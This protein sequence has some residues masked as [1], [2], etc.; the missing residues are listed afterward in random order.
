LITIFSALAIH[1]RAK[2]PLS[3][4]NPAAL[5]SRNELSRNANKIEEPLSN[6]KSNLRAKKLLAEIIRD[7]R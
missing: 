3:R 2:T 1:K 7:K 6:V 4:S 5:F